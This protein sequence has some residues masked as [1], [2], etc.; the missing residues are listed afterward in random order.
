MNT[1]TWG[2]IRLLVRQAL[3]AGVSLDEIDNAIRAR[4]SLVLSLMNWQGLDVKAV[5]ETNAAYSAGQLVLT[6]GSTAITGVGTLWT[7]QF[8]GWQLFLGQGP[9]YTVTILT[10][11]TA[12]LDR[13]FEGNATGGAYWFA[14]AVY[15]LPDSCRFLRSVSSPATGLA[16][17]AINPDIFDELEGSQLVINAPAAN[18]IRQPNG[19]NGATGNACQQ[20]ML[21]PVPALAQG[22]PLSFDQAGVAFDG[23]TTSEGP[24][25]FVSPFALIEGAKAD[26]SK[27]Q[28]EVLRC[29]ARF[30]T[31][32]LGMLHVENDQR[33]AQRMRLA[34]RYTR[35]RVER[36][37]RSG[38]P[39]VPYNSW[40]LDSNDTPSTG[41]GTPTQQAF[42]GTGA[43]SVFVLSNPPITP[44]VVVVAGQLVNPAVNYVS[45]GVVLS[46]LA[47]S[48]P[49]WHASVQV[50]YSY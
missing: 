38:G 31:H 11:T 25:D 3:P 16:L 2:Q 1:Y 19:V 50:F 29:E 30:Q 18:W 6:P 5:L 34:D 35:H 45:A 44:L 23:T 48:I 41:A 4:Y 36:F 24:L 40:L 9:V 21:W 20:I 17:N 39:G 43:Q 47:G 7:A 13:P 12:T 8:S 42:T 10:N 32:L 26:L 49:A 15:Q 33:P 14:R 28:A 27:D 46:F 37:L 22:Y